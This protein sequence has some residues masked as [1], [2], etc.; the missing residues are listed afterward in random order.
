MLVYAPPCLVGN[1]SPL[2]Y[3]ICWLVGW[4]VHQSASTLMFLQSCFQT[5]VGICITI[6]NEFNFPLTNYLYD[7]RRWEVSWT[8]TSI[9]HLFAKVVFAMWKM[10]MK[11]K[12]EMRLMIS[13]I[14][15][16]SY[17]DVVSLIDVR[18]SRNACMLG[19]S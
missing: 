10:M 9:A 8:S 11:M 7:V 1:S 3:C 16:Y 18:L 5:Q 17:N 13:Y 6:Y 15:L 4:C 19:E 2:S 12:I 14:L